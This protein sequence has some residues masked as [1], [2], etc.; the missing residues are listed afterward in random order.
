[1]L[2][3]SAVCAS[4]GAPPRLRGFASTTNPKN[5][6]PAAALHANV[7]RI[8][9]YPKVTCHADGTY[10]FDVF[11][12][13]TSYLD[14]AKK[15]G[16]TVVLDL[17]KIRNPNAK[18]YRK[19]RNGRS[20]DFW[21]DESNLKIMVSFWEKVAALC[22][23]REEAIWFDIFNEP[24]DWNDFPS[25]P[26]KWPVWAQTIVDRIRAIDSN[27]AI[28]VEPGPGGLCWG[29]RTFPKLKGENIIYSLH[30]YQPHLYTHQGVHTLAN[31]DLAK[32][33]VKEKSWPGY[34]K[35]EGGMWNKERLIK[36]LAPALNFQ[37]RHNV[38]MYV[39]E[40]GVI[41]WA[42]NGAQYLRDNIELFEKW[43]W[44]WSY[45]AF[46]EWHGWS[47]EYE[48]VKERIKAKQP[49]ARAKV[50]FEYLNRNL[51]PE[52]YGRPIRNTFSATDCGQNNYPDSKIG[53]RVDV[54]AKAQIEFEKPKNGKLT[55]RS[56]G[57]Q[58]GSEKKHLFFRQN[59]KKG[60]EW[61]PFEVSFTPTQDGMISIGLSGWYN[62]PRT[63]T[64]YDNIKIT[65]GELQNGSFEAIKG[66]GKPEGWHFTHK[67]VKLIADQ[68]GA[69]D[70]DHYVMCALE[71][72][73]QV[74]IAVK[75]GTKVTVTGLGKR[76]GWAERGG[77]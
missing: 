38:R 15:H 28:V 30:N 45:H 74:R 72:Y 57:K 55:Y 51:D 32:T 40:F 71:R 12:K 39:G 62:K 6:A 73:A 53:I 33:Y 64:C 43:G 3:L 46:R 10:D 58:D 36:E 44:D 50:L 35:K 31:T 68:S 29:Y 13:I 75:A 4:Y 23:D 19:D 34:Y 41:R 37:K 22:K 20:A 1:M 16:I 52:T 56:W 59:L 18:T 76:A 48:P 14:E 77:K 63:W 61:Q 49:T 27:H 60:Y 11:E 2:A 8:N 66:N 69:A 25:Y 5:L 70:G 67:E 7:I 26:K 54:K 9:L 42:D 47:F 21:K 65:G 17:H 24:L